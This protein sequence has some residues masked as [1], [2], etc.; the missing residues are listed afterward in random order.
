MA[1]SI[2]VTEYKMKPY[3]YIN[4]IAINMYNFFFAIAL[5]SVP[6]V[7]FLLRKRFDFSVKQAAVYSG[8]T[9][10]FGLVAAWITAMLKQA[11]LSYASGG[12]YTNNEKLRNY[13]IP[14]FLP[15]FFFIY[16]LIRKD[17][18]KKVSDYIAS[19]VYMVM[20]FVKIGCVF[21]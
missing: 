13:G 5:L 2:S 12:T 9:L 6:V 8:F 19:C 4:S 10:A 18:F 1:G 21:A 17:D 20:T 15:I 7:L 3:F 16:C 11:M 14:V